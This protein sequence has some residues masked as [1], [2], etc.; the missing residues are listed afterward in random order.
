MGPP[1]HFFNFFGQKFEINVFKEQPR[2]IK[3]SNSINIF[4][5]F[6]RFDSNSNTIFLVNNYILA[7]FPHFFGFKNFALKILGKNLQ[8]K[9]FH[10]K[11]NRS[12]PNCFSPLERHIQNSVLFVFPN[13]FSLFK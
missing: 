4:C 13:F 11:V 7:I 6:T 9:F 3:T 2:P 8:T 10:S 12:F 5:L 1:I